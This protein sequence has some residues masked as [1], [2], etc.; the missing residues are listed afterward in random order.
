MLNLEKEFFS[1]GVMAQRHLRARV[2]TGMNAGFLF[3]PRVVDGARE[4]S[5]Y[6][7][8]IARLH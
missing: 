3:G 4:G 8:T 2:F 1:M 6:K 5:A 7:N